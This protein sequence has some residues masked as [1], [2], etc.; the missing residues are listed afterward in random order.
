MR[1]TGQRDTVVD[2]VRTVLFDRPDM[3][4]GN[5]GSAA[6]IDQLQTRD[7]AAFVIGARKTMR[8]KMRSRT[9]RDPM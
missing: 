7:R 9:I 4:S 2:D 5:L 1:C 3:G 8:R 6:T